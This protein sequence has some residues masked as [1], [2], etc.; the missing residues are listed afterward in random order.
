MVKTIRHRH[1]F[2][3]GAALVPTIFAIPAH[4][5]VL[6]AFDTTTG[7]TT[8][9]DSAGSTVTVSTTAGVSGNALNLT[10]SLAV[11][12][13]AGVY[14]INFGSLNLNTLGAN[15]IRFS[16]RATSLRNTIEIKLSDS[17]FPDPGESTNSVF[18]F[19][20]DADDSW[21]TETIPFAYFHTWTDKGIGG[22][23]NSAVFDTS[24]LSHLSFGVNKEYGVAGSDTIRFDDFA[25]YR[26][27]WPTPLVNGYE[28]F[29]ADCWVGNTCQ[30]DRPV[31]QSSIDFPHE[32]PEWGSSVIVST[33][34]APGSGS[35]SREI[36]FTLPADDGYFGVAESLEDVAVAGTDHL[37]F[38]VRGAVGGEPLRLQLKSTSSVFPYATMDNP[39]A[40]TTSWQKVSVP[41]SSFIGLPG[42]VVQPDL[43]HITTVVFLFETRPSSGRVYLDDVRIVRPSGGAAVVR[44]LEDFSGAKKNLG[45]GEYAATDAK[46]AFSFEKGD[47]FGITNTVGRLDYTFAV[48]ASTPYAVVERPLGVNL[49]AEPMVN[50]RFKGTGANSDIE[51]KLKDADGTVYRKVLADAS[52]TNGVWK[53]A[54][55]PVDQFSFVSLGSDANL[56]LTRI[57]QMELILSRGEAAAGTFYVDSLGS[58]DPVAMEKTNVGRV[59]TNVSTPNNPFSPNGDGVKDIFRVEYTLS[60]PATVLFKV[61]NLQGVPVSIYDSGTREAGDSVLSWTGVGDNGELVPNGIYFFVLEADSVFSGKE[62]FRQIVAVMR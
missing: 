29:V 59:L 5:T 4:A 12:N 52:N 2:L 60:E 13:W 11:G 25:L 61:F 16:Y 50:F 35:H 31:P 32:H 15:A 21:H 14:K 33:Q 41:L 34:S 27:D 56:S 26:L 3:M 62:T 38:F 1:L 28:S 30:N 48:T 44:V 9:A 54:S 18:K 17:D 46:L 19:Q 24:A 47:P 42:V 57:E 23:T 22:E 45:Y 10:Y 36:R 20:A 40:I 8:V 43:N 6:D 37:E 58:E 7:W 55:I 39:T 51:V 49:L 53:T